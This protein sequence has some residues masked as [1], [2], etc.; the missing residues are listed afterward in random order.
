M[1]R[2]S[3]RLIRHALYRALHHMIGHPASQSRR[4]KWMD[5]DEYNRTG[6]WYCT[7][8]KAQWRIDA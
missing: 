3:D 1:K 4:F 2:I 6:D 7:A 5:A 8:C